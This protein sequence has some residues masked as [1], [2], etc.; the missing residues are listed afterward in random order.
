MKILA[1]NGSPRGKSGATWWVLEKFLKGIEDAG[2]KPEVIEL[3]GK[4]I[5]HCT[6]E[7][8]CWFKTPGKCI[9][10]DDMEELL[11]LLESADR[12]V[13]ATPVYVDG[14]SGLLK[15]FIDRTI[16]S[17][18]PH[19]EIRE[20][21]CRHIFRQ[22]EAKRCVALVSVCGFPELDNF[23]PLVEHVK[24]ICRNFNAAYAGAVLRPA[25]PMLPEI[26]TIH[27]LYF[28]MRALSKAIE[29]AGFEFAREGKI[30]DATAKETSADIISREQYFKIVNEEFDKMLKRQN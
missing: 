16:P 22:E 13:F 24:A 28:K 27:P 2:E 15:N 8:H 14:M 9:H 21:H 12:I 4:K 3:A 1:I 25:A 23:D 20:D 7:W 6:G 10:R 30:S 5:H 26:P 19:F 17:A 11:P 18:D 29:K